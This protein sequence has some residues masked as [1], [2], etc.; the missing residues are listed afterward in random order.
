MTTHQQEESCL[1]NGLTTGG[2]ARCEFR[3]V[4]VPADSLQA[5]SLL[6]SNCILLLFFSSSS[7]A[8]ALLLT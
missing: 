4:V 8:A 7:L 3:G 1:R 5:L 2:V 6:R